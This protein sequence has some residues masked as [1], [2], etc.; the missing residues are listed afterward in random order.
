MSW[1]SLLAFICRRNN[2]SSFLRKSIA[3]VILVITTS[4]FFI[5]YQN[6]DFDRLIQPHTITHSLEL[7]FELLF[8]IL[9][10]S[11][12]M[13][14]FYATLKQNFTFNSKKI[15]WLSWIPISHKLPS[16]H[17][18]EVIFFGILQ[19]LFRF[20]TM[21]IFTFIQ[22]TWKELIFRTLFYYFGSA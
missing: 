13:R 1:C 16:M 11:C 7:R 5:C 18:A 6:S 4:H 22:S 2:D 3:D 19:Y 17:M 10:L 20:I 15:F 8:L 14:D 9:C 12:K 21:I